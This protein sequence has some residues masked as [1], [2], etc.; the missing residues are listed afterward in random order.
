MPVCDG[1]SRSLTSISEGVIGPGDPIKQHAT[2]LKRAMLS[3][4]CGMQIVRGL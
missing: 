1:E 4:S 3:Y 2:L